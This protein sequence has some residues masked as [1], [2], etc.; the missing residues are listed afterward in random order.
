MLQVYALQL[1]NEKGELLRLMFRAIRLA[2]FLT[3]VFLL[4]KP[5]AAVGETGKFS[6]GLAVDYATGDYGTSQT[7]DSFSVPLM[8]SWHPTDRLDFELSIP[9]LYQSRST[10]VMIGGMRFPFETKAVIPQE[11][12]GG[13]ESVLGQR[14]FESTQAQSGLGDM[15]LTTGYSLILESGNVPLVRPLLYAKFP[16]ADENKGL[17]TG[18]FDFGGGLGLAKRTGNWSAYAEGMYIVPGRSAVF[19][20]DDYW[21]YLASVS[22]RLTDRFRPGISLSGATSPFEGAGDTAQIRAK[23]SWWPSDRF[24]FGGFLSKGLTD[25]SADFGAGIS[26]FASF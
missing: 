21:T 20:P 12:F 19:E 10:S 18:E 13:P 8:V 14:P 16:T 1:V 11:E 7:T 26:V 15:T 25:S 9:Y 23:V 22:Y 2:F 24:S 6:L 5:P 3:F 17:G 4:F